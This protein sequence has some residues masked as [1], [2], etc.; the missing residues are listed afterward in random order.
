ML[1]VFVKTVIL[2]LGL[3]NIRQTKQPFT[4]KNNERHFIIFRFENN[5][6]FFIFLCQKAFWQSGLRD[7]W[8]GKAWNRS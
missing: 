4:A 5:I 8:R 3:Q 1:L 2:Y 7:I 6:N